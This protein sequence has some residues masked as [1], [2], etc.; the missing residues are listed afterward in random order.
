MQLKNAVFVFMLK[1]CVVMRVR[2]LITRL[3]TRLTIEQGTSYTVHQKVSDNSDNKT[4]PGQ[5]SVPPLKTNRQNVHK[6][7][8]EP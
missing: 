7:D 8:S 4:W 5:P 2:C 6:H 3:I 1:L